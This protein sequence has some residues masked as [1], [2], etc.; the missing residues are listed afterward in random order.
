MSLK[1]STNAPMVNGEPYFEPPMRVIDMALRP[2]DD[3]ELESIELEL[4]RLL[5]GE[6]RASLARLVAEARRARSAECAEHKHAVDLAR[7]A[8]PNPLTAQEVELV[9]HTVEWMKTREA[10]GWTAKPGREDVQ[11]SALLQRIRSGRAPLPVPPPTSWGYPWYA[12]CDGNEEHKVRV[13]LS[14]DGTANI[15]QCRWQVVEEL[16]RGVSFV[17]T[18]EGITGRFFLWMADT[19]EVMGWRLRRAPKDL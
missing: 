18:H 12:L 6:A 19:A 14:G 11:K 5:D 7:L 15:N 2:L 16:E 3:A 13:S 17:V 9:E 8:E 4:A 10:A 1:M